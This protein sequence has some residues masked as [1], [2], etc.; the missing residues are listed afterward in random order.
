MGS[1]QE[2]AVSIRWTDSR[3]ASVAPL[4]CP[5]VDPDLRKG[6]VV[7]H[8]RSPQFDRRLVLDRRFEAQS[9]A[10]G[11]GVRLRDDILD[12]GLFGAD[13]HLGLSWDRPIS[14]CHR[15]GPV[16]ISCLSPLSPDAG[17]GKPGQRVGLWCIGPPVQAIGEIVFPLCR[18]SGLWMPEPGDVVVDFL[19][20]WNFDQLNRAF[21][22]VANR[23]NPQTR[24]TFELQ[25]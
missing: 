1:R 5:S 20:G 10:A 4:W 19:V 24:P 2:E 9:P 8:Q 16:R 14:G 23:L 6:L 18:Q 11:L 12:L 21:A 15:S 22:P 7:L 25:F 13:A 17:S 3:R